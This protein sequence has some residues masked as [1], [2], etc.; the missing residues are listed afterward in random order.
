MTDL[1]IEG[2]YLRIIESHKTP[3]GLSE[4]PVAGYYPV[5]RTCIS[6]DFEIVQGKSGQSWEPTSVNI[7]NIA[8]NT[9]TKIL[10]A[11]IIAGNVTAGGKLPFASI[12][13]LTTF[14]AS[15]TG[16]P[17]EDSETSFNP[18]LRVPIKSVG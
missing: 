17:I 4:S 10:N 14:L 6:F 7:H 11:D 2:N 16:Q 5:T 3:D 18:P 15:R 12:T 8:L 1:T 9:S 13:D